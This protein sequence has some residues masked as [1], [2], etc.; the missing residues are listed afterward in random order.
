LF[1]FILHQITSYTPH[2]MSVKFEIIMGI[3]AFPAHTAHVCGTAGPKAGT[4]ALTLW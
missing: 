1:G 2:K 3:F 4:A